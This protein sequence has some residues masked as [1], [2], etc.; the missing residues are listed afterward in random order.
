MKR[1][2]RSVYMRT[3]NKGRVTSFN[4]NASQGVSFSD[5]ADYVT[6]KF[7]DAENTV[8]FAETA[9]QEIVLNNH[10]THQVGRIMYYETDANEY[11]VDGKFINEFN[12]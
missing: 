4:S 2:L 11:Q 3:R 7:E 1:Y 10:R 5:E 8:A 9:E 12:S 6:I